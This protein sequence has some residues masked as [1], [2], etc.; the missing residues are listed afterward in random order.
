MLTISMLLLLKEILYVEGELNSLG[1]EV[2]LIGLYKKKYYKMNE[3][4][5]RQR[6]IL[7]SIL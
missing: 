5:L 4:F 7:L 3:S 6:H 1:S 2:F